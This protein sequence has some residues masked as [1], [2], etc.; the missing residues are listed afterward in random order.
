[1]DE[2]M[3]EKLQIIIEKY[4]KD[5]YIEPEVCFELLCKRVT[6]DDSF[7]EKHKGVLAQFRFAKYEEL[8][9]MSFGQLI[10]QNNNSKN[11]K[12]A[13]EYTIQFISNI[14]DETYKLVFII[15]ICVRFEID[16]SGV[17][18]DT[19][20]GHMMTNLPHQLC[21]LLSYNIAGVFCSLIQR[22]N[23]NAET[24]DK[25]LL[26]RD[27]IKMA[28]MSFQYLKLYKFLKQPY[29]DNDEQSVKDMQFSKDDASL[30]L[31]LEVMIYKFFDTLHSYSIVMFDNYII[32]LKE[33]FNNFILLFVTFDG[34]D[35]TMK[36]KM[37]IDAAMSHYA[38]F[39]LMTPK[40]SEILSFRETPG[41]RL[42]PSQYIYLSFKLELK[43]YDQEKLQQQ[44]VSMF[45]TQRKDNGEQKQTSFFQLE[46]M[47][48]EGI[49]SDEVAQEILSNT[50]NVTPFN[51]HEGLM[52]EKT[53]LNA[54]Q[55]LVGICDELAMDSNMMLPNINASFQG[56][57]REDPFHY[58][59][60]LNFITVEFGNLCEKKNPSLSILCDFSQLCCSKVPAYRILDNKKPVLAPPQSRPRP[61]SRPQPPQPQP[62]QKS[63]FDEIMER[64]RKEREQKEREQ[65]KKLADARKKKE[66][67]KAAEAI[68]SKAGKAGEA[69]EKEKP[70]LILNRNAELK[71]ILSKQPPEFKDILD[72]IRS[73]DYESAAV[74]LNEKYKPDTKIRLLVPW[75]ADLVKNFIEKNRNLLQP[76]ES[77]VEVTASGASAAV[78][79][80]SPST[81]AAAVKAPPPLS[82]KQLQ[83]KAEEEERQRLK[84]EKTAEI[85]RSQAKNAEKAKGK[86]EKKEAAAEAQRLL[87]ETEKQRLLEQEAQVFA[88]FERNISERCGGDMSWFDFIFRC[89]RQQIFK[90]INA[91]TRMSDEEIK[92]LLTS[93]LRAPA[94]LTEYMNL[95]T[96]QN[97]RAFFIFGILNGL[98]QP[99]NVRFVFTG[100]TFLQLLS[101]HSMLPPEK[102]EQFHIT[103]ETS[104][105]D[106]YTIFNDNADPMQYR[107][108]LV[109]IFNLFWDLH[110]DDIHVHFDRNDQAWELFQRQP[111][112][113]Y[114]SSAR[115]AGVMKVSK[116]NAGVIEEVSDFGFNNVSTFA[117]TFPGLFTSG[118]FPSVNSLR[119][120]GLKYKL[121]KSL[122]TKQGERML[123]DDIHL[124]FEFPR[125]ESGL[126]EALWIV[127][128]ILSSFVLNNSRE[129]YFIQVSNL[130]KFLIRAIQYECIVEFITPPPPPPVQSISQP[131]SS[132]ARG[133]RSSRG[134]RNK[135]D[136]SAAPPL[137]S[138]ESEIDTLH[139]VIMLKFEQ[140]LLLFLD[141]RTN[142]E[143]AQILTVPHMRD[144]LYHNIYHAGMSF[145]NIFFIPGALGLDIHHQ[146]FLE[147]DEYRKTPKTPEGANQRTSGSSMRIHH[148]ILGILKA[149][150]FDDSNLQQQ[151]SRGR[152]L[153]GG[154]ASNKYSN[155]KH[156][157]KHKKQKMKKT[158]HKKNKNVKS[159]LT[160]SNRKRKI[161]TSTMKNSKRV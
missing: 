80:A 139:R 101:C 65:E 136:S 73:S 140:Q 133:S 107:A 12:D 10:L 41:T 141:P 157:R 158:V 70:Q 26:Q 97:C 33:I 58:L 35:T 39:L 55:L 87:Q 95:E 31:L 99:E 114:V 50:L 100:R 91:V 82:K 128:K 138:I 5:K 124:D 49:K 152:N 135:N 119:L 56:I 93:S 155:K 30:N 148:L 130:L 92:G 103:K 37:K 86:K 66:E 104:D 2:S 20:D 9:A 8:L 121:K 85:L 151:L 77:P 62:P 111:G 129:F 106:V 112:H 116:N 46:E 109:Y 40:C 18:N 23:Y 54:M 110:T 19:I 125:A 79:E 117:T 94:P 25:A 147:I 144:H 120:L 64:R 28:Q 156:T 1:M 161:R 53:L 74:M 145:I 143:F 142:P 11:P 4:I 32:L 105:F 90:I 153:F 59:T 149:F 134:S 69:L 17:T 34:I 7:Y 159:K 132:N 81:P 36:M 14:T 6:E 88:D 118:V 83:K 127:I 48:R 154:R 137:Q 71:R 22:A 75:T 24:S 68:E 51:L 126:S 44:N 43:K 98:R 21:R 38:T 60:F 108:L 115:A 29:F 57:Q 63:K 15:W 131:P 76:M 113:L 47:M 27:I 78:V 96:S 84:D 146:H 89:S 52:S 13:M 160:L 42:A 150:Q 123:E 45:V 16:I 67:D 72:S 102:C 3:M 122:F 61:Q